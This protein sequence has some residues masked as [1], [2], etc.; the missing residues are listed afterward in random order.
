MTH[1]LG[2][3]EETVFTADENCYEKLFSL[4]AIKS[5]LYSINLCGSTQSSL[6][7]PEATL[8]RKTE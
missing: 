7:P 1:S 8:S 2:A 5:K 3:E 4:V 6:A